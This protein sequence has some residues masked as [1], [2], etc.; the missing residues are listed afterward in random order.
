[1][2]IYSVSTIL[3]TSKDKWKKYFNRKLIFDTLTDEHVLRLL[4]LQKIKIAKNLKDSIK[5]YTDDIE[6]DDMKLHLKLK[7]I[8]KYEADTLNIKIIDIN[9]SVNIEEIEFY[10]RIVSSQK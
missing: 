10:N 3:I 1:M 6:L 2:D 8:L 7:N 4:F 5:I 9:T